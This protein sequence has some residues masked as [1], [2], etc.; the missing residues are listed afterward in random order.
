MLEKP[1]I[2]P[3]KAFTVWLNQLWHVARTLNLSGTTANR[4]TTGLYLGMTYF[5]TTLG[6]PIWLQS[7]GPS[8]WCDATGAAV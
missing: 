1:P 6:K 7:V 4:P 5:D 8:V 2:Q 3:D